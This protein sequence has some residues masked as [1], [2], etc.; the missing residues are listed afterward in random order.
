MRIVPLGETP[1]SIT[2]SAIKSPGPA[3]AGAAVATAAATA[4]IKRF[5]DAFPH[6]RSQ[7]APPRTK[8]DR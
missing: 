8:R 1:K 4:I 6:V 3:Q 5:I 2:F 7:A